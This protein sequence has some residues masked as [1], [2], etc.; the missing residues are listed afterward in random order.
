MEYSFKDQYFLRTGFKTQADVSGITYGF[1]T[2]FKLKNKILAV[3]YSYS[4]LKSFRG[5]Q[6]I[7]MEFRKN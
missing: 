2:K 1:G 7:S 6:Q 3:H 5:N 4:D